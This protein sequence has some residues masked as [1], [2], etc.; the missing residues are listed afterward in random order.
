MIIMDKALSILAK[1]ISVLLHPM[2]MPCYGIALFFLSQQSTI[3]LLPRVYSVVCIVGT[4]VLTL[5]IPFVLLLF[6]WRKGHIDS[7]HIHQANQRTTPY[8]YT[9]ICYGFW[10]YF[11]H[12]TVHMPKCIVLIAVGAIAAL[13]A[14]VIIN[15]WWKISAHLTGIGGVL[16]GI[17]SFSLCY[18]TLPMELII[19]ILFLSLLL[20][21]ARLYMKA[22]TPM[23]VVC[24]YLLGIVCTFLPCLIMTYA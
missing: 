7:L 12:S 15:H 20:M 9:L 2:L 23:Q 16:G 8:V 18:A 1:I 10:T 14:V 6:L 4:F 5:V 24:G 13:L 21:Y 22:H 3:L 19:T 17:C 11:L